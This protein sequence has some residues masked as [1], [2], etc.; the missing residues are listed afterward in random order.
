MHNF[1]EFKCTVIIFGKQHHEN[2]T[3]TVD[4]M[5]IYPPHEITVATL[6]C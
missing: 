2:D 6:P 3:K 4:S 1:N 5:C